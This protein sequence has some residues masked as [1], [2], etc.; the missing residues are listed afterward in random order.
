ML[1]HSKRHAN[2]QGVFYMTFKQIGVAT[3]LYDPEIQEQNNRTIP[4]QIDKLI[5]LGVIEVVARNQKQ[6]GTVMKKANLYR[7]NVVVNVENSNGAKILESQIY[8]TDKNNDI[9]SC[10]KFYYTNTELKMMLPR[11]QYEN[12]MVG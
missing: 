10:M 3:G 8:V 2:L 1:I 4:R 7:M 6:K 5:E 12:V 11:R 9:A